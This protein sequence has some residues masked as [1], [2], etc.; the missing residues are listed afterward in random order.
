MHKDVHTNNARIVQSRLKGQVIIPQR[1]PL[2]FAEYV[3]PGS[4]K[5]QHSRDIPPGVCRCS[6]WALGVGRCDPHGAANTVNFQRQL[7]E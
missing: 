7:H 6:R 3:S 1:K 2:R 5:A 4:S